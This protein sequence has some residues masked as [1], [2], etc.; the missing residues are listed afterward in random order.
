MYRSEI[1]DSVIKSLITKVRNKD[2]GKYLY[3]IRLKNLRRFHKQKITFDFPVT[4][5]VAPNGGGKTTVLGAAA[6]AYKEVKPGL[7]FTKSGKFDNSMANWRMEYDLIDKSSSTKSDFVRRTAAFKGLKWKRDN[8]LSRNV[9][10]MGVSRTVPAVERTELKKCATKKFTVNS[11]QI[12]DFEQTVLDAVEKILGKSVVGYKYIQ[13]DSK[14]RVS[15]LT[16]TSESGTEFSEFHFGAG[17]SSIIRL[18]M[19][20]EASDKN[21]LIL[22]EEIE[23]GLHPIATIRLVEYLIDVAQRKKI[24]TIFTTH[25]DYALMPLPGEAIWAAVDG[26]LTQGKLKISALREIRHVDETKLIIFTEDEFTK[27]WVEIMLRYYDVDLQSVE[28]HFI[29]GDGNAVLFN[30]YN[31]DNPARKAPSV[32]FI[33]GDSP[34]KESDERRVYRLPGYYPEEYVYD[35]IK[36]N[37]SEL[38]VMLCFALGWDVNKQSELKQKM[39]SVR[40]TNRDYHLLFNQLGIKLSLIPEE[41]VRAAFL[42]LYCQQFKEEVEDT[43]QPIKDLLPIIEKV[44]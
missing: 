2:Y 23:N 30:K 10:I 7:F 21:S 33:D 32:C 3:T 26:R 35:K 13:V 5:L 27:I 37:L 29:G 15:L 9:I 39:E 22:I 44:R 18:I 17:E 1:R 8:F 40:S 6:L 19:E 41:T 28:V 4:A 16:G 24:Q 11:S 43:L 25:S 42:N 12:N 36:D 34:Q 31:N 38:N 20:V 14:G